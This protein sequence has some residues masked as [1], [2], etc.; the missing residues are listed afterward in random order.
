MVSTLLY[1]ILTTS[2]QGCQR[3]VGLGQY[4]IIGNS[5]NHN[6][7]D[8]ILMLGATCSIAKI[9]KDEHKVLDVLP[10]CSNALAFIFFI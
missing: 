5:L 7:E 3:V 9:M 1:H 10:Q 2:S 6:F 8:T 4:H